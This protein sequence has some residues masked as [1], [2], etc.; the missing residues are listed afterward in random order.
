MGAIAAETLLDIIKEGSEPPRRIALPTE[1]II[2]Q[3][4]GT[5]I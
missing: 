5:L 1:L 2:R 4:C 3:T